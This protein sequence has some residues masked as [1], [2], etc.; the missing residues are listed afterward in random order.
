L[1]VVVRSEQLLFMDC[2]VVDRSFSSQLDPHF[3]IFSEPANH[4]NEP[5][6]GAHMMFRFFS[7]VAVGVATTTTSTV[8][9]AVSPS[10]LNVNN[11][12]TVAG[13]QASIEADPEIYS[14]CGVDITEGDQWAARYPNPDLCVANCLPQTGCNA[15]TWTRFEGGTCYFKRLVGGKG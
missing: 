13:V 1:H 11:S 3:P 8:T 12:T 5:A 2:E 9:A 7:V 14:L 4:L 6:S 10:P 15:A